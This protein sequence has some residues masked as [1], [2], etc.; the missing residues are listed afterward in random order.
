M[1]V[2]D[3]IKQKYRIKAMVS[4]PGKVFPFLGTLVMPRDRVGHLNHMIADDDSEDNHSLCDCDRESEDDRVIEDRIEDA[5]AERESE[6]V[7]EFVEW[8]GSSARK[9]RAIEATSLNHALKLLL[10]RGPSATRGIRYDT[11]VFA[12]PAE[13]LLELKERPDIGMPAYTIRGDDFSRVTVA[14]DQLWPRSKVS[15]YGD[16]IERQN[17]VNTEIRDAREML[18][19][20]DFSFEPGIELRNILIAHAH[21][22]W[23]FTPVEHKLQKMTLYGPEGHFK[24]HV[25]HVDSPDMLGTCVVVLPYANVG[26]GLKFDTDCGEQRT[27]LPGDIEEA[28][29][30]VI[31]GDSDSVAPGSSAKV[32]HYIKVSHFYGNVLHEI[33]PVKMGIRVALTFS[34]WLAKANPES[35]NKSDEIVMPDQS[36]APFIVGL[37]A[38]TVTHGTSVGFFLSE[39]YCAKSDLPRVLQPYDQQLYNVVKNWLVED[40]KIADPSTVIKFTA[41]LFNE[42]FPCYHENC[43]SDECYVGNVFEYNQEYAAACVEKGVSS[44]GK[45]PV[46]RNVK[47][48]P[49]FI[50]NRITHRK[51]KS[52]YVGNEHENTNYCG[53]YNQYAMIVDATAIPK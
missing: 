1:E 4:E 29:V 17:L 13:M 12:T 36:P 25:D 20:I 31:S 23:P 43:V 28:W 47:F 21:T 39:D 14:R 19:E 35:N 3:Y 46:A 30:N 33:A 49:R 50:R 7:S 42:G 48:I 26:G 16:Q 32:D 34:V 10:D 38:A 45:P 41:V 44:I 37:H 5:P 51:A 15:K 2:E 8:I 22:V 52:V 53:L 11:T 6:I 9:R 18:P 40:M 24:P 27:W